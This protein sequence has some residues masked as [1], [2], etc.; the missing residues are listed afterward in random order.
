MVNMKENNYIKK[1]L[2]N[3]GMSQKHL[4]EKLGVT[5]VTISNWINDKTEPPRA[6]KSRVIK[7]IEN[8]RRDE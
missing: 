7:Y 6:M 2:L 1:F 5:N 8:Y 3:H 4:A